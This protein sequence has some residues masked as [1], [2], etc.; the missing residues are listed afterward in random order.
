MSNQ[1]IYTKLVSAGMSPAGACGMMGN[2]NAESA[3]RA[4]N[5]QDGMTRMSDAEYT[6]AVDNGSYT[7]FV[8]DAVGYG[9]CQWTYHTR[10]Q[11]LLNFA[12]SKGVSIG[13]EDMQVEFAIKELK[14]D[15]ASLWKFLCS[16]TDIEE[17][18]S[19]ICKEYERPAVNNITV[20]A[21][22]AKQFYNQ[23]SG[24]TV[25]KT[26]AKIADTVT[27]AYWPPRVI[28]VGMKGADI[29]VLQALLTAHGYA[30][31]VDGDFGSA[32]TKQLKAYQ[33]AKGLTA[34]GIVGDKSWAKLLSR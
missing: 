23:F 18:A 34:D 11:E 14:R 26:E 29:M 10:K 13:N 21:N 12:K 1:T 9:L 17:A 31:K 7:N 15:N 27:T 5:A 32:T 20:R 22:A 6:A 24:T 3:M 16:T 30:V 2:M 33:K 4:N 19:R 28:A 8:K 25:S